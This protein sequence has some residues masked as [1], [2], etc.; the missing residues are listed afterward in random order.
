MAECLTNVC[1]SKIEIEVADR[2]NAFEHAPLRQVS[3]I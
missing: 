2:N 1:I 3:T